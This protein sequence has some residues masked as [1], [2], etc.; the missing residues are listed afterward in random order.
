MTFSLNPHL[1]HVADAPIAAVRAWIAGREF[2]ADK[3]LLDLSQAVPSYPPALSLREHLAARV[4][5]GVTAVY[6]EIGGTPELRDALARHLSDHYGARITANRCFITAGCNQAFCLAVMG[7]AQAGDEVILPVPYYFNHRMWLDMTGISA[8][9]LPFRPDRDGVPDPADAEGLIT[10]RTRAL[11]LVSPNNPTG[12]IYPPEIIA[13]F[14][15]LARRHGIAL[16]LDETYKDFIAGEDPPHVLFSRDGWEETLIQL[17]SFSKSYALAGYRVGSIVAGDRALNGITKVMDTV[18]IC[19]ARI[20]QDAAL[21]GLD[22]LAAWR[23][24]KRSQMVGR[25]DALRAAFQGDNRLTYRLISSGAYF[26]YVE[27]PFESRT[28]WDVAQW[29]AAEHNLLCL[30]GTMFGSGQERYLRLAFANMETERMPEIV[31][32]LAASQVLDLS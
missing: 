16:I 27:H 18:S 1:D 12:A 9:P 24:E 25:V 19:A 21:Y 4:M 15:E 3:P 23:R 26:A 30:P 5:D 22:N 20:G 8:V 13:A 32:R 11:V 14:Y 17:F 28:D 29:L 7:L 31:D 2:P 6:T 10:P